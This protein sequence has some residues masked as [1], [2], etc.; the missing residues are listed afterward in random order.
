IQIENLSHTG[1]IEIENQTE[2][3]FIFNNINL[4]D[5]TNDEP[6]SHGYIAFKIKPKINV[7][8]GDVISGVAK[9]YFDFNPPIITNTVNT[10]IVETLSIDEA[11]AETFKLY[12]NPAKDL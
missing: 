3:R 1:R 6:N 9:I 8:V 10:E 5:S 7:Q 4:P 12:P 2:V 11:S